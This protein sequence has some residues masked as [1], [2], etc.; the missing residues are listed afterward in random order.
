MCKLFNGRDWPW[1]KL[2]VTLVGKALLSKALIQLSAGGWGCTSS[3]VVVWPEAALGSTGSMLG[4]MMNF[5]VCRKAYIIYNIHLCLT[6][7]PD[8]ERVQ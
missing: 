6:P 5:K 1:E 8:P 7:S 2:G 3:L 4:L